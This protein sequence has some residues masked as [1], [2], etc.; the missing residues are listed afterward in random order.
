MLADAATEKP[1]SENAGL[2]HPNRVGSQT[3]GAAM[4]GVIYVVPGAGVEVG[5]LGQS[6]GPGGGRV[7]G[8]VAVY[9]RGKRGRHWTPTSLC[10]F[11]ADF[12]ARGANL[13][14]STSGFTWFPGSSPSTPQKKD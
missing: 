4:A 8:A 12:G 3:G 2:C 13:G 1:A 9:N 10:V 14:T 7:G 5:A 11:A 6:M